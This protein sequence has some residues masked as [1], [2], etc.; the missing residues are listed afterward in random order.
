[1]ANRP[2]T[3]KPVILITGYAHLHTLVEES[4]WKPDG[5]LAKPFSM[6]DLYQ[7]ISKHVSIELPS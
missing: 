6:Y 5:Y 2:G 4:K 1:M 7:L 3:D